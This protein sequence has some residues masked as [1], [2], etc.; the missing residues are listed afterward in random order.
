[1]EESRIRQTNNLMQI[2]EMTPVEFEFTGIV[3]A[4]LDKYP[5]AKLKRDKTNDHPALIYIPAVNRT[6]F[7]MWVL[8]QGTWANVTAPVSLRQEVAERLKTMLSFYE[9]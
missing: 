5:S 6:G 4:V 8:S 7:I 2:G 3:E 9:N 1:M